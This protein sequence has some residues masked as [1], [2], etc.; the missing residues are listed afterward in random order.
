M[1][2]SVKT[3]FFN[4]NN[5]SFALLFICQYIYKYASFR[6]MD[7]YVSIMEVKI[8]T[9]FQIIKQV[10]THCLPATTGSAPPKMKQNSRIAS[11]DGSQRNDV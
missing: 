7:T 8:S 3:T 9:I 1:S 11:N 4:K 2:R 5:S 10:Y 6:T